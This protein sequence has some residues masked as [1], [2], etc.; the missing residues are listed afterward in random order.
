M[1]PTRPSRRML[2]R[3]LPRIF[4]GLLIA[5]TV[6]GV[7]GCRAIGR[8]G[9][10]RQSIAA[11]QLSRQGQKAMHGGD[12]TTA[13]QL[14]TNALEVSET[15]DRAHW[16]LAESL[17]QSGD[18][19]LAVEHM[20]QAVRLSAN[21]PVLQSRL[22]RM[23]AD[24][25][26]TEQASRQSLLALQ[27]DRNSAEIWN[28]RGDC[29]A[30]DGQWDE[31]LSAYHR[32]LALQPDFVAAQLNCAEVYRHQGRHDRLLASTDRLRDHLG[33]T[34]CPARADLLRG[35][36][37]RNLG[38]DDEARRC[39]ILASEKQ[40]LDETPHLQLASLLLATGDLTSARAAVSKAIELNPRLADDQ[41]TLD[42]FR[43]G[44][45]VAG[46]QQNLPPDRF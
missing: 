5:M 43:I 19:A 23:Y 46:I 2:A 6:P 38:R 45:I 13:E 20:E 24:L 32:A 29:L 17:W 10:S 3:I 11:R 37:M 22:G 40:P 25:G 7:S 14:F 39:F 31:A 28:L 16:G 26:Q 21:D 36:A 42:Q 1:M 33:P 35:L 44:E 4:R 12:W 34:Q 30:A 15:D 41:R 9:Q 18:H 8:F 27:T